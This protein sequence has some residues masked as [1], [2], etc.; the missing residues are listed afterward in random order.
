MTKLT[1]LLVAIVAVLGVTSAQELP[2]L[3]VPSVTSSTISTSTGVPPV[4][5]NFTPTPTATPTVSGTARPSFTNSPVNFSSLGNVISSWASA[6]PKATNTP[7]PAA[8]AGDKNAGALVAPQMGVAA[9]MV[10]AALGTMA[11]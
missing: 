10:L 5:D 4:N 9:I 1:T 6:N 3:P 8:G 2:I 11:F 7:G